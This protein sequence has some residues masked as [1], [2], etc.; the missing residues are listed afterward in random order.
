MSLIKH[1]VAFEPDELVKVYRHWAGEIGVPTSDETLVKHELVR[2]MT[3]RERVTLRYKELPPRCRD[4]MEWML[5]QQDFAVPLSRFDVDGRDLP[6]KS[7]EVEAVAFALKQRGFLAET[8]D[9]SWVR[10]DEP[11]YIVPEDLAETLAVSLGSSERTL[12]SQLSLRA[13]LRTVK[14]DELVARLEALDLDPNLTED[15]S[16]L[17]R[18][19]SQPDVVARA[20]KLLGDPDLEEA[21]TRCLYDHGGLIEARH[22]GRLGYDGDL[23]AWRQ[24]LERCLLGTIMQA[25]L[26]DVGLQLGPGTLCVFLD[27][28]RA[29]LLPGVEVSVEEEPEPPAD[30]LAD[31]AAIRTFIDH[32]SVRV[33]RDGELYRATRRK[34]ES[35]I[36]SPGARPLDREDALSWILRFLT[37]AEL[38]RPDQDGRMRT[39]RAWE[40]YDSRGPVDRTDLLLTYSMNDVKDVK[41]AFHQPRLRKIFLAVL[42]DAG[43]SRW[44]SL[45][46]LAV[47]ARNRYLMTLDRDATAERF[48]KRY[49][50]APIPPLGAP[51]ILTRGLSNF[52]CERLALTGVLEVLE[53]EDGPV[54]VRMTR[55]GAAVLGLP[56]EDEPDADDGAMIVTADFEI[57]L[58]PDQG[59]IELIHEVGRFAK[60]EKAD[61]SLH[62]RISER[63]VQEAVA[64]G[65]ASSDILA[66]LRTHGRHDIP[67]NVETSIVAW[68]DAVR[69]LSARRTLLIE[70]PCKEALDAALKV[71]ELRAIAGERFNDTVIELSEDPSTPRVAEALLAQGFFLR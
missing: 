36:L 4:F 40:D 8:R 22:L 58:F 1:L 56:V 35:E 68:A 64:G 65:M 18:E 70:A 45:R 16:S 11:V 34:M 30:I 31:V 52:G 9:L 27:L 6:V 15:R 32:H 69:V 39:T 51:G 41:G 17:L 67:Q 54:G 23:S 37:D 28:T 61:Y 25:E 44:L 3:D 20:L 21:A 46:H 7:F 10:Y 57:V 29:V 14:K 55:M 5:E 71:K 63:T 66:V 47:L 62:Y 33:T 43:P 24:A 2:L 38:V 53:T 19:L 50:Y 48:Q 26:T 12:D 59:G 49:K 60:R 42:R 13:F